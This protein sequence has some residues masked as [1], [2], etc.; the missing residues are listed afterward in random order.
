MKYKIID[1]FLSKDEFSKLENVLLGNNFPWY[2]NDGI[3]FI[4]DKFFQFVHNFYQNHSIHSDFY[5]VVEPLVKKIN[6]LSLLRIKANLI[7]RTEKIIEHGMHIDQLVKKNNMIK[8]AI[9]YCNTNDGYS[10]FKDGTKIKSIKNR[11]VIFNN[12]IYHTG[13]TCTDK[14][15]RSVINFNFI[16]SE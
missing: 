13:T 8:T 16:L 2:L 5:P 3:N 6:P 1:N 12:D 15:I 10:L 9:F 7:T 14:K 4:G 11:I